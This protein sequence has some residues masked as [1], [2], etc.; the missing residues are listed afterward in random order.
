MSNLEPEPT[1]QAPATPPSGRPDPAMGPNG[2]AALGISIG[3]GL[4]APGSFAAVLACLEPVFPAPRQTLA[5]GLRQPLQ[6]VWLVLAFAFAAWAA[7][8]LLQLWASVLEQRLE[9][10]SEQSRQLQAGLD[11][12]LQLLARIAE[13][14][15]RHGEI[16]GSEP[17][18]LLERA[19]AVVEIETALRSQEWAQ[20][21]SLLDSFETVYPGDQKLTALRDSLCSARRSAL[22]ERIAELAAAR[23]VNDPA[24]VLDLYRSVAPELDPEQRGTL[25]SEVARWFLTVIYRRLRTGKIQ[26]D[27]VE[28]ADE[29]V[30]SFAATTEGASVAAAL[31]TLRRSAGLCPRCAQP[32][33]GVDQACPECLRPR[34]KTAPPSGPSPSDNQPES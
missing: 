10:D 30:H 16:P 22:D 24:R 15:D 34:G 32:Y 26:V 18:A 12:A 14:I 31:P 3:S 23:D 4:L 33:T 28:L 2:L 13:G 27:V 8:S 11:Q 17:P 9:R 25:Q 29:F 20:A 1:G 6:A 21:E 7:R 19:H 5:Q